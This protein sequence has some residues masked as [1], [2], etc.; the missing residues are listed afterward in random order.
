MLRGTGATSSSIQAA[1][2]PG[3][4]ESARPNALVVLVKT[5]L[6]TPAATDSSSRLSV[7]VMLVSTKSCR[8]CDPT[9]GL[10]S[11]AAWMTASTPVMLRRTKPLSAIEPTALVCGDSSTSSPTTSMPSAPSTRTSASPR[12]PELPVTR[13][14]MASWHSSRGAQA[15]FT[16]TRRAA[17]VSIPSISTTLSRA[18]APRTID[19]RPG[20]IPSRLASNFRMA[21]LALPSIGG[22]VTRTSSAPPRWP[23]ISSRFARGW[24]LTAMRAMPPT[25]RRLAGWPTVDLATLGRLGIWRRHVDGAEGLAE[26]EGLGYGTLWLG[27]SPGPADVRPFLERTS[28][29][30]IATGILNVWRHDPADVAAAHRR[31]NDEFGGRVPP[32]LRGRPR[33]P[34]GPGGDRR[35]R[36]RRGHRPRAGARICGSVSRAHQLLGQPPPPRLHGG[37]SG[38]RRQRQ[39][40]RRGHPARLG[41]ARGRGRAGASRRRG[42]SRL[43]AARRPRR[44]PARGLPGAGAGAHLIQLTSSRGLSPARRRL[45]RVRCAWSE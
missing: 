5:K 8:V 41:R 33:G 22:A 25:V 45:S 26:L 10:W 2:S 23:A 43:P 17:S 20:A 15:A 3:P 4:G 27:V 21:S 11:V 6:L 24:T 16:R 9:C 30:T 40:H 12:W 7:P 35:G 39:A 38:E 42:G 13:T 31:L 36:A 34:G 28:T 19:T 37:R 14:L 32:G 1:G 18:D 29:L 44:R